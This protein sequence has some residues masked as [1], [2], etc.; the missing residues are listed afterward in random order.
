MSR[1]DARP[2]SAEIGEISERLRGR[3]VSRGYQASGLFDTVA[4]DVEHRLVDEAVGRE[5]ARVRAR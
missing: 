3:T 5:H 2:V 1:S 4:D